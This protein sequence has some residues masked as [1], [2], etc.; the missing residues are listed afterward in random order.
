MSSSRPLFRFA[1]ASVVGMLAGATGA[2]AA[3]SVKVGVLQSLTGTMAISEVTVKAAEMMALVEIS[4]GGAWLGHKIGPIVGD[5]ASARAIFA[6]KATK[7]LQ[8]DKVARVFG[9]CPSASRK[10]MLPVFQRLNGLLWYPVQFE[11]N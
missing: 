1:V 11:G 10:A 2:S 3:D 9:G 8:S 5:G 4:A 6:Q 7:L